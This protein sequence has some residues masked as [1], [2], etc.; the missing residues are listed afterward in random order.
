MDIET[1]CLRIISCLAICMIAAACSTNPEEFETRIYS[2]DDSFWAYIV[3]NPEIFP[4][5]IYDD[6]SAAKGVAH[7]LVS[8]GV[9]FDDG[10]SI[11]FTRKDNLIVSRNKPGELDKIERIFDPVKG[12]RRFFIKRVVQ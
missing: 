8:M 7:F 10:A 4:D 11:S 3:P 5:E 6:E 9:T 1:S 12:D 2:V